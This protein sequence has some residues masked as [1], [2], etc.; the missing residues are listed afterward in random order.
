M[1]TKHKS[2]AI[3]TIKDAAKMTPKGRKQGRSIRATVHRSLPVRAAY[4][5]EA[6]TIPVCPVCRGSGTR[7]PT[8]DVCPLCK[9]SGY[10]IG[11]VPLRKR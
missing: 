5:E 4:A 9:G 7:V 2:A 11:Y 6:M 1:A 3:V 10:P 8:T